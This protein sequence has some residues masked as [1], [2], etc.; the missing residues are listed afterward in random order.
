MKHTLGQL[1]E[2]IMNV[3]WKRGTVTVRDVVDALASRR[4]AYTTVMT[5]M[6]RLTT[7]R[8]LQRQPGEGG[9]YRYSALQSREVFSTSASR[10]AVDDL[11]KRYGA[12]AFAQ[13]IDRLDR[14]PDRELQELRRRLQ[15]RHQR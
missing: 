2:A 9:A 14:L 3:V 1:E 12:V 7:Q 8:L 10:A 11:V 15:T 13:F 4:V 5:V 6:T